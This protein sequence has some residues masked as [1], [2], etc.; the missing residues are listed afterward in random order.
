MVPH[1][2]ICNRLLWM[3]NAFD[4]RSTDRFLQN[5]PYTFDSAGWEFFVPLLIGAQV[6][7]AEPGGHQD[8]AYLVSAIAEHEIT[9]LQLVPSMLQIV[10]EEPG[11]ENCHTLR[12]VFC[13]GEALPGSLHTRFHSRLKCELHNLYGPTEYSIDAA[14]WHSQPATFERTVPIGRA[15]SNTQLYVLDQNHN[16]VAVGMTGELFIG[17]SGL[18]RAYLNRPALTAERFVPHCFSTEPGAR[19]Y[20]TGDL[21]RYLPDGNLEFVGRVDHQ[22]KVRGFRIELG[23]IEAALCRHPQVREA[24]VVAREDGEKRLV[25]YIVGELEAATSELRAHLKQSLP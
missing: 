4:F 13:G 3:I 10:L 14:C 6:V 23:E 20:R 15:L 2:G 16:P 12:H 7:I 8:T 25:A 19:L 11:F 17:G 9:V 22:V 18:A 24:I 21:V 1:R 5:T